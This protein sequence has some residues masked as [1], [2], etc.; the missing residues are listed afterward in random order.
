MNLTYNKAV[1]ITRARKY[2]AHTEPL[3]K[4]LIIMKL[5]DSFS[6][7]FLKFYHKFK[8]N[9]LPKYFANIFNRNSDIYHYGTR[10]R[11][12]LHYFP[13]KRQVQT[14]VSDIQYPVY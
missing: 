3:L 8:V 4:Q 13:F 14:N 11:D 9:S 12:Q 5:E 2:D 6:L 1:R 10:N 7:Q